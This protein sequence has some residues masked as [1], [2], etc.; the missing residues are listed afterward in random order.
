MY[1]YQQQPYSFID[2]TLF[3]AKKNFLDGF[4]TCNK[5]QLTAIACL[6]LAG[7]VEETPKKCKDLVKAAQD[8]LNQMNQFE[9]AT[10]VK[11]TLKFDLVVQHPFKYLLE[12]TTKLRGSKEKL[13]EVLQMAWAFVNDSYTTTLCLMQPPQFIAVTFN[14]NDPR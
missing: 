5:I 12:I 13:N 4:Y 9:M 1:L 7:K 6:F 10:T 3:E 14:F 2:S 8:I 11:Q